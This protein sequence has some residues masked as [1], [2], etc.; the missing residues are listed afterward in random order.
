M[1][2]VPPSPLIFSRSARPSLPGVL[3]LGVGCGWGLGLVGASP[4]DVPGCGGE[5]LGPGQDMAPAPHCLPH[6]PRSA[7]KWRLCF[8]MPVNC[9]EDDSWE[10]MCKQ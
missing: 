2:P 6:P 7:A 3:Q 9:F 5:P 1:M 8:W 10:E 4:V